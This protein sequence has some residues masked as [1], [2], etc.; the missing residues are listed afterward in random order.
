[1]IAK[2]LMKICGT[3]LLDLWNAKA[4]EYGLETKIDRQGPGEV[5]QNLPLIQRV[6]GLFYFHEFAP[7]NNIGSR[8]A[9]E[10]LGTFGTATS[11]G[12]I[13][14][15]VMAET[16]QSRVVVRQGPAGV[17]ENLTLVQRVGDNAAL[18]GLEHCPVKISQVRVT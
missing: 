4:K 2:T 6:G 16:E 15:S 17:T 10:L 14:D 1:M 13:I 7:V 12:L 18:P 11:A 5:I 9:E 8:L 3:H